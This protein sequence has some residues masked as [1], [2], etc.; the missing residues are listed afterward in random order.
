MYTQN[1]SNVPLGHGRLVQR[2]SPF[3]AE[4]S[5]QLYFI[6]R[7]RPRAAAELHSSI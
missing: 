6:W 7:R 4:K 1:N 3:D 5:R 2:L